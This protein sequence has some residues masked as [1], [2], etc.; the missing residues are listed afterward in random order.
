MSNLQDIVWINNFGPNGY[1]ICGRR[2]VDILV[3]MGYNVRIQ[4]I[5]GLAKEDYL[6]ALLKTEVKDPLV[7]YHI[8][9]TGPSQ[10][11]YYT[12]TE[13]KVPPHN[14]TVNLEK[15]KFIMTQSNFCKESFSR[16]TDSNKIKI[17][18]FPFMEN[19]FTPNGNTFPLT[20]PK[21][22]KFKFLCV[23][24]YD[25][26]KN[27]PDLMRAFTEEFKRNRDVCLILKLASDRYCIPVEFYKL[28]SPKKI[29]WMGEFVGDMASLYRSV[30]AYCIAD[31]GEGWAA[32]TTEAMLCGLPAVAPGHSGHLDYM[33]NENSFLIDVGDWE[34]IGFM[35]DNLYPGLLAPE[36][37]WKKPKFESIKQ[38]LRECYEEF[39]D[40]PKVE[41]LIHPMIKK[42]LEVKKIVSPAFI[43]RQLRKAIKWYSYNKGD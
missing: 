22:Y 16:I 13:V 43:G 41:R 24:R 10:K 30:D 18:N 26:R 14:Q 39:K 37:E 4:P 6:N 3:K 35:R 25:V 21:K 27:I 15:A 36:M 7:V 28:K 5:M 33:N 8:T 29:F 2:Y 38:K 32:P 12:V 42:A 23:A 1:G 17:V 20:I 34:K 40:I 19:E 11:A 9:P 31:N